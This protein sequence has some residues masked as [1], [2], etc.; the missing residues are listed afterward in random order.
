MNWLRLLSIIFGTLLY[1]TAMRYF[2]AS[3][4]FWHL[5]DT[6][7][8]LACSSLVFT[9]LHVRRSKSKGL[10]G[11]A[12]SYL[13][14]LIWQGLLVFALLAHVGYFW[15]TR[16][17]PQIDT[18][19]KKL[20]LVL[21][22]LPLIIALS[23]A[24]GMETSLSANGRGRFG[25]PQRVLK[26]GLG[27]SL[28]GILLAILLNVNY[29]AV[30]HNDVADWSYL[31]VT[32]V[33]KTTQAMVDDLDQPL[34]VYA[35]L[36]KDNE[37]YP[38]VN[39]YLASLAATSKNITVKVLDKDISPVQAEKFRVHKN[40][41][42]VLTQVQPEAEDKEAADKDKQSAPSYEKIYLGTELR[43][44]RAKLRGL[45]AW[46]QKA[47]LQLLS[48]PRKVYFT[49]GHGEFTWDYQRDPRRSL[50][51]VRSLLKKQNFRLREL[52]LD[53]GSGRA[54]PDDVGL[55]VI[56]GPTEAFLPE[57]VNAL[58]TYLAA[59]GKAMV[60]LD[61][62]RATGL[63]T[64]ALNTYPLVNFLRDEVGLHLRTEVLA[65]DRS[66]VVATKSMTDRWFLF[67]NNFTSHEAV[68]TMAD[69]DE[70]VAVLF[71]HSG[72]F[73][74]KG[75]NGE[76]Q[77]QAAMKSLPNTF[78]DKNKN[79]TFDKG[80]ETRAAFDICAAAEWSDKGGRI[81]ACA[82]ATLAADLFMQGAGNKLLF[83]DSVQWLMNDKYRGAATSEQDEKIIHS[84]DEDLLVFYS[85]IVAVPL[86]L[87]LAGTLATRRRKVR[88]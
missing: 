86:L 74:V 37:V 40:G 30:E 35:F 21:W 9:W 11:E 67:S 61:I 63:A 81:F 29:L 78:V 38:F 7:L 19:S 41:N 44:A 69:Y 79:F 66:Y 4:Y 85:T 49:R 22:L 28:V 50:R 27:W 88:A 33:S 34:E 17:A 20:L 76:W 31:K 70:Q 32:S 87:L 26:S 57:E 56:A 64:T 53:K 62:E 1:Y 18:F 42:L 48:D 23:V 77:A 13:Y 68:A 43:I 60:L 10:T 59:G 14:T 73:D 16:D 82:D 12:H 80:S 6:G 24:I 39:E 15:A 5:V 83:I 84:R 36:T 75:G 3:D 52:G 72:Y 58:R 55:V 46:I 8:V 47:L 51:V 54:F 65:N 45:D 2:V 25:E 71:F